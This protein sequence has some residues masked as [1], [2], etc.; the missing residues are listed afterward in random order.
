MIYVFTYSFKFGQ[1]MR[2]HKKAASWVSPNWVKSNEQ[3][4]KRDQNLA[5]ALKLLW[6]LLTSSYLTCETAWD[7]SKNWQSSTGF[8]GIPDLHPL[9][10]SLHRPVQTF[11]LQIDLHLAFSQRPRH[12]RESAVGQTLLHFSRTPVKEIVKL[13]F[14][15]LYRL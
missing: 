1:N 2:A 3:R 7:R 8:G 9:L 5:K 13:H 11:C 12:F 14:R 15:K 4:E 10:Q 6:F